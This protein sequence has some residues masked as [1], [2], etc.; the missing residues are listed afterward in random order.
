MFPSILNSTVILKRSKLKHHKY[1]PISGLSHEQGPTIILVSS[2][3]SFKPVSAVLQALGGLT[4][5]SV[6]TNSVVEEP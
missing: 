4:R 2:L 6:S 3:W 1:K 5:S